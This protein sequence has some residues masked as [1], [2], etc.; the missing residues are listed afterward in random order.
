MS[1]M[2]EVMVKF[3]IEVEIHDEELSVADYMNELD[4][5]FQTGFGIEADIQSTE[6]FDY[7]V[8][9][10]RVVNLADDTAFRYIHRMENEDE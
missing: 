2:L 7:D 5:D 1:R 9:E 4:Y 10:E 6:M 8:I 3:K